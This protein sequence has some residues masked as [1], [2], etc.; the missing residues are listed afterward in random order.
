LIFTL[1]EYEK[2][3]LHGTLEEEYKEFVEDLKLIAEGIKYA[4]KS[5]P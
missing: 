2:V 1:V 3:F 5:R 4:S